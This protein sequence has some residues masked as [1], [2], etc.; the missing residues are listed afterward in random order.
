M[1]EDESNIAFPETIQTNSEEEQ[2]DVEN[3]TADSTKD[4]ISGQDIKK[5]KRTNEEMEP[6]LETQKE[7][8]ETRD[9]IWTEKV[10]WIYH[11]CIFF[12]ISYF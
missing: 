4:Q 5:A 12:P 2:Y 10:G 6:R 3:Q 8:K 1:A 7:T 11:L 9:A